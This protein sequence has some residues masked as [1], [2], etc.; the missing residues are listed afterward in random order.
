LPDLDLP[1]LCSFLDRSTVKAAKRD[2]L[3]ALARR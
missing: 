2:Y 1:L 3:A